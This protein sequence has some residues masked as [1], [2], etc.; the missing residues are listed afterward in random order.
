MT[1]G[2]FSSYPITGAVVGHVGPPTG[3]NIEKAFLDF[4]RLNPHVYDELVVLTRE[5]RSRGVMR[6]GIKMLF[7]VLRWKHLLRTSGDTFKLN[8]NYHSYYAR[9]IMLNEPDLKGIFETRRLHV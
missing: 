2:P 3:K 1:T 8:N 4:H 6:V 7:E 5:L 9:L